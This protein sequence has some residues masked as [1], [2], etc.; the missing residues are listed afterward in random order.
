VNK[1][2]AGDDNFSIK[3]NKNSGMNVN[4]IMSMKLSSRELI[5]I[6][7]EVRMNK[8]KSIKIDR[9]FGIERGDN[10]MNFKI[11]IR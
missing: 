5:R 3:V 11:K 9:M 7:E 10:I 4:K 1:F 6:E 8:G 2:S